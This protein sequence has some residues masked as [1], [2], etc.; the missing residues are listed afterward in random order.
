MRTLTHGTRA[1]AAAWT[2]CVAI[3]LMALPALAAG[4]AGAIDTSFGNNGLVYAAWGTTA[5]VP[6]G[7][8]S[9]GKIVMAASDLDPNDSSK[10]A[11]HIRRLHADGSL[12]T[13]FGT[14]G[15]VV[16]FGDHDSD[17]LR[18][19]H[20]DASDRILLTG[21]VRVAVTTTSG[22][23]KKQKT[24]TNYYSRLTVARLT[25]DGALDSSFGADG[26]VHTEVPGAEFSGAAGGEALAIDGSG[27]IVVGGSTYVAS[28]SSGGGKGKKGGGGGNTPPQEALCLLRYDASGALDASFGTDGI[29]VDDL[30]SVSDGVWSGAIGI[31]STGHIV[32][33]GRVS[34]SSEQWVLTRYDSTGAKDTVF[35]RVS[36]DGQYLRGLVIDGADGIVASGYHRPAGSSYASMIVSRHTADGA[37]DTSFGVNG[38]SEVDLGDDAE[39]YWPALQAD[40]K[41]VVGVAFRSAGSIELA[42]ARFES[43]G[44]L[45]AG[46][47]ASG[48]GS[49][50]GATGTGIGTLSPPALDPNGDIVFGGFTLDASDNVSIVLARWCGS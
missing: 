17:N 26:V 25:A 42:T 4:T 13:S 43:G 11:W 28:S 1:R 9:D 8:Q 3:T 20:I 39:A 40:G 49:A 16:L 36:I 34:G 2:T 12:D 45:D 48:L 29:T 31:Q 27:N 24:E 38:I 32:I 41:I 30:T 7:T 18:D 5:M 47:G 22:R 14:S 10:A 21:N 19:M 50:A 37:V 23:G 35:G 6:L 15:E 33:G 46:F 44:A